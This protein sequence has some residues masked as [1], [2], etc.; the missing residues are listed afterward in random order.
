MSKS[1][2]FEFLTLQVVYLFEN[3]KIRVW[4]NSLS[5]EKIEWAFLVNH[6]PVYNGYLN[7]NHKSRKEHR[8]YLLKI[9]YLF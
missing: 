8:T 3:L 7:Y 1:Y 9:Y 2:E 4:I 5:K 6:H